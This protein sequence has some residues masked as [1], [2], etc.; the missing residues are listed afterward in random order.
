MTTLDMFGY[1]DEILKA[2]GARDITKSDNDNMVR[3]SNAFN[4]DVP[5]VYQLL[6]KNGR[7]VVFELVIED[8]TTLGHMGS[9]SRIK[10]TKLF[11]TAKNAQAYAE[12]DYGKKIK[13]SGYRY[14]N[15]TSGD[16]SFVMYTVRERT[17]E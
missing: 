15:W 3:I 8:L 17:V 1:E 2:W 12:A 6:E 13:W 14:N 9:S 16:L 10:E 4:V 7:K 11:A 5:Y